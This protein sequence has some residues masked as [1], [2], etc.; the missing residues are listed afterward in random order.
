M[1]RDGDELEVGGVR[2]VYICPS[3][4]AE[5]QPADALDPALSNG[6]TTSP[7]PAAREKPKRSPTSIEKQAEAPQEAAPEPAPAEELPPMRDVAAEPPPGAPSRRPPRPCAPPPGPWRRRP[8]EKDVRRFIP[9]VVL[10]IIGVAA[11]GVL[12]ALFAV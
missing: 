8:A 4:A 9:V 10:G 2:F 3:E 6:D 1:L 11:L 5:E 12:I 7:L